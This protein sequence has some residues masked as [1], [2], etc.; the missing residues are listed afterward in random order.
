MRLIV[1]LKGHRLNGLAIKKYAA[2]KKQ[3]FAYYSGVQLSAKTAGQE[4]RVKHDA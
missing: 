4:K 2:L 3:V 1:N